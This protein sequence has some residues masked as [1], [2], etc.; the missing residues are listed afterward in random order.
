MKFTCIQSPNKINR[1]DRHDGRIQRT[2]TLGSDTHPIVLQAELEKTNKKAKTTATEVG[3]CRTAIKTVENKLATL[4]TTEKSSKRFDKLE[5]MFAAV[6]EPPRRISNS[7]KAML[8]EKRKGQE[9][10][11]AN[12]NNGE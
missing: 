1:N 5:A 10:A 8:T 11:E 4:L 2:T 12:I 7:G 9:I 6:S 3:K